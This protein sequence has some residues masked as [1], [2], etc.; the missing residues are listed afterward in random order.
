MDTTFAMVEGSWCTAR[1]CPGGAA[2]VAQVVA[3]RF[4]SEARLEVDGGWLQVAPGSDRDAVTPMGPARA[5]RARLAFSRWRP[6]ARVSIEIERWSAD[7]CE[8]VV[9]PH[10]RVPMTPDR[11]FVVALQV[12]EA[13]VGEIM[14]APTAAAS[15]TG[16]RELRR[17]S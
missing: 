8:V 17:A 7:E 4:A 16:N 5:H 12:V 1:R 11:Y 6:A 2:E 15:G 14:Q 9:R 3:S 10:R 13:L